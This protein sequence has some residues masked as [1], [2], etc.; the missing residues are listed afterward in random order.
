MTRRQ[1]YVAARLT[2][3]EREITDM[4]LFRIKAIRAM[5][6][7]KCFFL[8]VFCD[9]VLVMI[10]TMAVM[11]KIVVTGNVET[12]MVVTRASGEWHDLWI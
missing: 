6:K 4:V 11:M 9:G 2:L 5:A 10:V 3:R 7:S 12:V 8:K 1:C